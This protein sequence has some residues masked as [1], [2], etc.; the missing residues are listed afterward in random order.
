LAGEQQS[1]NTQFEENWFLATWIYFKQTAV[2]ESIL[3]LCKLTQ[4]YNNL[5]ASDVTLEIKTCSYI[6]SYEN[7]FLNTFHFENLSN[8]TIYETPKSKI[9]ITVFGMN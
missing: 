9:P 3:L 7:Y 2:Y 8:Q 1:P 6:N 5:S 4:I